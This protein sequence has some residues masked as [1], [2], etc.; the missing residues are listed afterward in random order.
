MQNDFHRKCLEEWMS[1]GNGKETLLQQLEQHW[2][3]KEEAE[4]N[5]T[6]V[7]IRFRKTEQGKDEIVW[8]TIPKT[9]RPKPTIFEKLETCQQKNKQ[10][11][12]SNHD[13]C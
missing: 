12:S 7:R 4:R 13:Q 2:K 10:T 6:R 5:S 3:E 9:E 8:W 11:E 1:K